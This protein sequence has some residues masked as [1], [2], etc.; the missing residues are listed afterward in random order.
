M[1]QVAISSI[2]SKV[3]ALA[4]TDEYK[5]KM[6]DVTAKYRKN[7]VEKT[8][9]GSSIMTLNRMEVI[10]HHFI[11]LLTMI[12][13]M[14]DLPES[15]MAHFDSLKMT[16]LKFVK[17][18]SLFSDRYVTKIYFDDVEKGFAF[19][20]SLWNVRRGAYTGEGI[21]NIISLF[22]TGYKTRHI[23]YGLWEGHTATEIPSLSYRRPEHFIEDAVR[24]FNLSYNRFGVEAVYSRFA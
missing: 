4:K 16:P 6:K 11:D 7:N 23:V 21:D 5:K 17:G 1:A 2:M 19:R 20:T 24:D 14:C 12:A 18:S 22:D 8:A 3:S 13:G 15:V 9:A 10:A